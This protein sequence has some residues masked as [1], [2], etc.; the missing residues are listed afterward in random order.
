MAEKS[1]QEFTKDDLEKELKD[2][3]SQKN[4]IG[5]EVNNLKRKR[6]QIQ[7]ELQKVEKK[8]KTT[9]DSLNLERDRLDFEHKCL[10]YKKYILSNFKS[11]KKDQKCIFRLF[12]KETKMEWGWF[13]D[14]S[15][16]SWAQRHFE[17]P[18][19]P[20][21]STKTVIIAKP[22]SHVRLYDLVTVRDGNCA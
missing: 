1:T 21:E 16:A 15:T 10:L 18:F 11:L 2:I 4:S 8:L 20:F 5:T 12:V 13:P 7:E 14:I 9:E 19:D 3:D 22:W 6:G 17:F